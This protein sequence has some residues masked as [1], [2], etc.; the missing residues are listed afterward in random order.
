MGAGRPGSYN[1]L[2][3]GRRLLPAVAVAA[4]FLALGGCYSIRPPRGG[5]MTQFSGPRTFRPAD[6]ALPT[7][8]VI[9]KVASG[10]TFPTDVAFDDQGRVYV[11]EAGYAL[12]DSWA[13]PRLLRIE[14]EGDPTVVAAGGRNGPWTSATFR[15]GSF[16]VAEGGL[17]Q[18]GRILKI[19]GDGRKTAILDGLPGS[20]DYQTGDLVVGPDEMLYFGQ[21]TATNSGVVGEDNERRGWLDRHPED[22][23]VLCADETL[24]GRNFKTSAGLTGAFSP[25]L[26]STRP[27]QLIKGR[28]PCNGAVMRLPLAG[29]KPE[30]VAWGFR[31]PLGLAFSPDGRLYA[32]D[33]GYEERGSRPVWAAADFLWS[34]S[35]GA[36]YGWPDYSG[37]ALVG[38]RRGR[39]AFAPEPLLEREPSMPPSPTAILASHAGTGGLDFSRT[40]RFG[41]VGDA[42]VAQFGDLSPLSGKVLA[43]VGFKVVRVDPDSG[44]VEDFAVNRGRINGPASRLGSGGLE[45]PISAR[46]D[47]SGASLYVV[48]FGVLLVT[49]DGPV[50]QKGTGALWRI[51]RRD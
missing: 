28:L 11:V 17:L 41:Y 18:G 42:F 27:G 24:V 2:M 40:E 51:Y 33:Q 48:D 21:G 8:Y 22:H 43:P 31:D 4:S 35:T 1:R 29:G 15:D 36:W 23:D 26:T 44:D 9:E 49:A 46:F 19:D 38:R 47:P 14:P 30:L 13:Q 12:G 10:L 34:V 20:G 16:Y 25:Y 45:R 37:Q 6:I 5:G 50:A 3:T 32:T 7:G 39:R